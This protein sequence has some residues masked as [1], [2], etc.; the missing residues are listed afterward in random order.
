MKKQQVN[1]V[2]KAGS[3]VVL[4]ISYLTPKVTQEL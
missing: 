1:L 3:S 2:A 4:L